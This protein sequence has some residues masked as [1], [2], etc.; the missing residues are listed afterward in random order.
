MDTGSQRS[1]PADYEDFTEDLSFL[2]ML[3]IPLLI[4]ILKEE[5]SEE[6]P[7]SAALISDRLSE[8]TGLE[9][10]EKTVLRKLQRLVDLQKKIND[11]V[12]EKHLQ[13]SLGGT[14]IE[15][16]NREKGVKHVQNR[17]YFKPL[18]EKSDV[19]MVCG[20]I[21]SNRYLT[22]KEKEYLI[23]REKTLCYGDKYIQAQDPLPEKP[24]NMQKQLSEQVLKIVNTLYEAIREKYQV[25]V[26]YGFYGEDTKRYRYPI[27]LKKNEDKPY[28]LNPYAM[29]WNDG[30]Y[31]LLATHRGYT[32]IS[33][34][35]V[36]RIVS[37]QPA[38]KE[39]DATKNRKR[40][41]IPDA[42]RTFFK[43]VHGREEFQTEQYTATYPLMVIFGE[44]DLCEAVVECKANAIGVVID[45]FGMDLRI[46]PPV[47]EHD[48]D[49]IDL[50]GRAQK[51]VSIR[52][53]KAQY[54][55]LR[56]FCLLQHS[57][58]TVVSPDRL[59]RDVKESLI[60]SANKLPEV[61]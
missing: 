52:L 37:V 42:L 55:N 35:R 10:S 25:D 18:L 40:E 34:F 58:V 54:E 27:L 59:I 61:K 49:E 13:L 31:Y 24:H 57:I 33:H 4:R 51:Y 30:E 41:P 48:S 14:M 56:G 45:Y 38:V 60:D 6:C 47:L 1:V 21:T 29:L 7:M 22:I 2:K 28:H 19:D 43:R 36:D 53:P 50:N 5:A 44:E 32:N 11:S 9:H 46:M 20:T 8:I 26:I 15:I 3:E 17:Y 12:L 23:A 16:S 39:D